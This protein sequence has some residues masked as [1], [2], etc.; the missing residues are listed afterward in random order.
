MKYVGFFVV[1]ISLEGYNSHKLY[2]LHVQQ[3]A[4]FQY[5]SIT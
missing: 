5:I 3:N 1:S 2:I 4:P